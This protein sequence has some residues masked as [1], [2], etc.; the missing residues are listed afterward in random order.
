MRTLILHP[1][2]DYN[3][4]DLLTYYGTKELLTRAV[5]GSQNLDV[6]QFDMIRAHDI[7]P[8]TYIKEYQWG[9]IDLIV[10]AGS[11]WLW[12][13]C[14]R[15][16]KYGL[17]IDA[18]QRY[19]NAKA[20]GLGIGSCFSQPVYSDMYI[21]CPERYFKGKLDGVLKNRLKAIYNRFCYLLVRDMFAEYILKKCGI[22]CK[23]SYDTSIYAYH[24]LGIKK[25]IGNKK[26][27]FFYHPGEGLS[28]QCLS[29]AID[30]FIKY[31]LNWA[32]QN[33]A[34]IYCNS[35]GEKVF[36]DNVGMKSTFS[37]DLEYLSEK[38]R[39]YDTMLSG[40]VHMAI[41][42]FLSG[43][44]SITL[45]PVDT[46]FMTA[47][48]FGI[49]IK[50]IGKEWQYGKIQLNSKV[51]DDIKKCEQDIIQDLRNAIK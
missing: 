34:D 13:N 49:K 45:L 12:N 37:V 14:I 44:P 4:G 6:V 38:F 33:N 5:G 16:K 17:L 31:Q 2:N 48:K 50:S 27:L 40:R 24:R 26:I 1:N 23:F 22:K 41:L 3:C 43:I 8:E 11:P 47:L 32:K 42:G 20:I 29:F 46:R 36:L 25:N 10:L 9:K 19:K 39:E 51:W 7:E 35:V 28:G 21:K 30:D 18:L 15:S